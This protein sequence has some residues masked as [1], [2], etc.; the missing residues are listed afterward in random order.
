[1]VTLQRRQQLRTK[2]EK[3]GS[4]F[5]VANQGSGMIVLLQESATLDL[6]D[7]PH[8]YYRRPV[9][10]GSYE[11]HTNPSTEAAA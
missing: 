4:G 1:M 5:V 3:H 10:V 9:T 11:E 7:I 6:S 8:T 2:L